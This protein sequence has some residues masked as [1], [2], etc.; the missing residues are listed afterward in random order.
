M[1]NSSA[2]RGIRNN[3]PGNLRKSEAFTW[4]GEIG[5]DDAGFVIFDSIQNGLRALSRTLRTYRNSH[6][7][8]TVAGII[9]RWAPDNENDTDSYI[10][11]VSQRLGVGRDTPLGLGHYPALVEAIII[12]ENGQQPY[13]LAMIEQGVTQGFA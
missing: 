12:H 10:E 2:P 4:Q 9:N 5:V 3:N 8:N 7:L 6:G 11:S 13:D 1:L